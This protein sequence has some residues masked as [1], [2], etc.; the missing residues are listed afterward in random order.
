MT[1]DQVL[2]IL[3]LVGLAIGIPAILF[4]LWELKKQKTNP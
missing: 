4:G 1:L 2:T 3:I